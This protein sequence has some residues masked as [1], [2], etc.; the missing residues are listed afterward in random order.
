MSL[1][2][3]CLIPTSL[4]VLYDFCVARADWQGAAGA[5]LQYARRMRDERSCTP[6]Q[7]QQALCKH[8]ISYTCS[9]ALRLRR[10]DEAFSIPSQLQQ[11]L[12]RRLQGLAVYVAQVGEA[13]LL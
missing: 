9:L 3:A 6:S 2:K 8:L 7:L 12:V 1:S 10:R 5:Q 11:A 4:Q 13:A